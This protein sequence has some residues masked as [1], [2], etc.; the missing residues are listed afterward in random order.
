[1]ESVRRMESASRRGQDTRTCEASTNGR[2][3]VSTEGIGYGVGFS[4]KAT[5]PQPAPTCRRSFHLFVTR[6]SLL[7][8][9][10]GFEFEK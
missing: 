2:F 10:I 6:V 3:W 5:G 1:M 9:L 7:S 8:S 4:R